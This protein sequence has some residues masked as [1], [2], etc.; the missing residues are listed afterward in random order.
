MFDKY[1]GRR[2]T[3]RGVSSRHKIKR[4]IGLI[5]F[6]LLSG[7]SVNVILEAV[8][9]KT[10]PFLYAAII[11]FFT[12]GFSIPVGVIYWILHHYGIL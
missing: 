11:G 6:I 1:L 3:I 10:I 12:G 5:V 4:L 2:N 7:W 9:H 8:F